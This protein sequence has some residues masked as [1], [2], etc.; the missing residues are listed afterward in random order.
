[1]KNIW[2]RMRGA[3][4]K[5][6]NKG[7][8]SIKSKILISVIGALLVLAVTIGFISSYINYSSTLDTLEQALTE[9]VKIAAN[10]VE[11]ELK[12]YKNIAIEAGMVARLSSKDN[13]PKDKKEILKLRVEEY[14][15]IDAN[16]IDVKGK[17]VIDDLDISDRPYFQAAVKGSAVV[18]DPVVSKETGELAVTIAAPLWKGGVP[19]AKIE[20]VVMFVAEGNFLCNIVRTI[21]V[22]ELGTAY[23]ADRFGTTIADHVDETVLDQWN[24]Q[25][26]VKNDE[27]LTELANIEK[28]MMAQETGFGQYSY[29][30][31]KKMMAYAPIPSS[32]Q[33]SMA[34]TTGFD[35][36]MQSTL[37]GILWIIGLSVLLIII[38]II[39]AVKLA[40]SIAVPIKECAVRLEQLSDGDLKTAVPVIKSK[41]ETA[42]LAAA[43]KKIVESMNVVISDLNYGLGE[44][45]K[46]NFAIESHAQ[47]AFVGDFAPLAE[48]MYQ[49][50]NNLSAVLLQIDQASGQVSSGSDQVSSGAQALSQGTTEQASSVQEL[51]A[52]IAEISE[53]VKDNAVNAST[54][55]D[56]MAITSQD[57]GKSNG[58]MQ[59]LIRA[60][61]D[62]NHSS[63]EIGKVIKT[64]EDI[65][66]QTNILALNAAVEA[67]RAG[68]AGKGFAVVADEV[69][70]LASKSAEAAKGTTV[71][72]EGAVEAIEN[73]TRLVDDTAKS[74][75]EVVVTAN[76]VEEIVDQISSA[77][78]EQSSAISQVTMGVDQI[79]SVVQTNSATAEESAAASEELSSQAAMLK[80]LVDRFKLK[81]DAEGAPPAAQPEKP[82]SSAP[83]N[84][85]QKY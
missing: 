28:H 19:G 75:D 64:I 46:G 83:I 77:S 56:K 23:I 12:A 45:G 79:S 43:T 42:I 80:E 72:I 76:E 84:I 71:L 52:T 48:S 51:A 32:N 65:A 41:D 73:G 58:K 21:K 67:A 18:S 35:E 9:S 33:W 44:M 14:G 20:G 4:K 8:T 53:Q 47:D 34:I 31:N 40:T 16:L 81:R 49:I 55:S 7:K 78:G 70:S 39:V 63:R 17:S 3:R 29:G 15:F 50:L 36:Y 59:E 37:A 54:A 11:A 25:E 1:M 5:Q 60:M 2:I 22:G 26:E 69:R 38:G 82:S 24:T 57:I 62:I 6:D 27:S 66:F 13:T 68:E 30:G 74:L 10:Q 85:A 61:E